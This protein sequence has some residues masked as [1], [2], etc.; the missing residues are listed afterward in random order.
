MPPSLNPLQL[1]LLSMVLF[2]TNILGSLI[3]K[4]I[5]SETHPLSSPIKNSANPALN[6]LTESLM[7]MGPEEDTKY[8]VSVPLIA[9]VPPLML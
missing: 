4:R 3:V 7:G 9:G 8:S 6:P 2:T 5:V 1:T